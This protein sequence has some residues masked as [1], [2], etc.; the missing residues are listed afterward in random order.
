[1][2]RLDYLPELQRNVILTFPCQINDDVPWTHSPA[3][4]ATRRVAI[5]TTSGLHVRGDVSFVSAHAGEDVSFRVIPSDAPAGDL[6]LSHPS[7]SF[8]R[9]GIQQDLNVTFPADRLRELRD[10][11]V[12]GSVATNHYSFHGAVRDHRRLQETTGAEVARL[13]SADHVDTVVLTG[14]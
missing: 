7:I 10:R 11:G 1:M 12:I 4:L 8:D 3:P 6:L 5:V 2:P 9:S 14:P 13:L